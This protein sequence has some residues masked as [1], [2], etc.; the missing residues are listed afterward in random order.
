MD[1]TAVDAATRPNATLTLCEAQL[2]DGC[3]GV[4]TEDPTCAKLSITGELAPV[5]GGAGAEAKAQALL[6][7]RHPQ[8]ADWPA[9]HEFR[10]YELTP[11]T[12]RLLDFYGGPHD[13][14][15]DEYFAAEVGVSGGKES[16][17]RIT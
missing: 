2:P 16:L 7:A 9:G 6:F 8:M 15:P 4:D 14:S 5:R 1:A 12:L 11:S 17:I 3:E 13:I 10:V